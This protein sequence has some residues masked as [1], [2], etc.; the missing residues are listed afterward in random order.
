MVLAATLQLV[1]CHAVD[2]AVNR[3]TRKNLDDAV[4]GPECTHAMDCGSDEVCEDGK[5][6][7]A[8]ELK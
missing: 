1:A 7:T 4:S 8:D 2:D 3:A 5:C 6:K